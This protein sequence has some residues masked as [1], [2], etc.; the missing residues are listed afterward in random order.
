MLSEV[1]TQQKGLKN[2]KMVATAI[3]YHS[4]YQPPAIEMLANL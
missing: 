2:I 1:H 4:L 3:A